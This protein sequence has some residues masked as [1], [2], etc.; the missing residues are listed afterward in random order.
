MKATTGYYSIVQYCADPARRE[1][2]NV[3]VVLL[4]PDLGYLKTRMA[5]GTQRIKEVF[6]KLRPDP[7]QLAMELRFVERRLAIDREYFKTVDDLTRFAETRA[8]AMRLT[9]P[10]PVLVEEPDAELNRLFARLV[11]KHERRT[12]NRIRR[13][14]AETFKKKLLG[15]F[16]QEN[17]KVTL[18]LF[19]RLIKAPFGF[20]NGRFNLIQATKFAGRKLAGILARAG[21]FALEG[22]LLTRRPHPKLGP[23]QLVVVAQFGADQGDVSAAVRSI[24]QEKQTRLFTLEEADKLAEEIRQTAKPLD[25]SLFDT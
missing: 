7:K 2:A 4:C 24:F 17:V 15:H 10:L 18:P 11:G 1:V 16:I 25:P 22:E 5:E 21:Q 12:R 3:G 8:A 9:L 19:E 14:L 6:P 23:L 13:V 20:Q